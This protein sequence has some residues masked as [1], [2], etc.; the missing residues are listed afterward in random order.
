LKGER[1]AL[2]KPKA[3]RLHYLVLGLPFVLA[4]L[5]WWGFPLLANWLSITVF[6]YEPVPQPANPLW[7]TLVMFF[8]SWFTF[9]SIGVGGSLAI[10]AWL[11]RRRAA[12][13]KLAFYPMVSF[14]VPALNEERTLPR[15]ISSLYR[16]AAEY[17]GPVEVIVVDDGSVDTTYEVAFAAIQ[18]NASENPRVRGRVVRHMAN[19]GKIE[20]LRTGINCALGQMVAVVDADSWW[21]PDA[22]RSLVEYMRANG[23]AAVTGYVH[24]CDGEAGNSPLVALQQ[25]EYS[26]GLSVFRCA[27]ALGNAVTVVPGAMGLFEAEILRGILNG[28]GL[29]SVTEDSEITLELQKRG[30]GVG[31][32]NMARS[33]TV[34]PESLASFWNQRQ[35][36]FIGWLHNTLGVHRDVLLERRWLSLLLWYSLIVE[37]FGTLIELAALVS[38]PLLYW[39][40]LDRILFTLNLL[41]FGAYALLIGIAA[42]AIALH[43]AYGK[44]SHKRLLY[45][46]PFYT[47]L[48]LLNLLARTTSLTKYALGYRGKWYTAKQN[49]P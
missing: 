45:Y 24:P 9:L 12:C 7:S 2:S 8:Y 1:V 47:I 37:Y 10:G 34:A 18:L 22:L 16:C 28:R 42:Q 46:T 19:L 3:S 35:R 32:L 38:F 48:W 43:Y 15:C 17:S 27:Q 23:K 40:A 30:H 36:W 31:Y 11:S 25:L 39:F 13:K 21:R 49:S 20:A 41:W 44:Q 29:K 4:F 6:R 33:G 14:V 5:S 26:Q